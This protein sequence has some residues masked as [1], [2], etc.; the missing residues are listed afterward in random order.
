MAIFLVT[1]TYPDDMAP[2]LPMRPEHRAWLG[3]QDGILIGGMFAG[4]ADVQ[5]AGADADASAEVDAGA[6]A[7]A[8]GGAPAGAEPA[9]AATLVLRAESMDV[10]VELMNQDPYWQAGHVVRRVIRQW[11]PPLGSRVALLQD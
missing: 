10:A 1:Y 8:D 2:V 7:D 5:G 11:D 3:R 4:P 6:G 9:N